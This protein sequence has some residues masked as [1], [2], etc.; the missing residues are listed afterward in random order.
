[1]SKSNGIGVLAGWVIAQ[2]NGLTLVGKVETK[3]R[4]DCRVLSPVFE[5]KP[6][7]MQGQGGGAAP[8]HHCFPLWLLAIEEVELPHGALV[9]SVESLSSRERELLKGFIDGAENILGQM[10]AANA[11]IL[12][13]KALPKEPGPGLVRG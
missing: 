9:V 8:V 11:G 10:K 6:N 7:L 2:T 5:M 1:M 3:Q 4:T 13:A 12:L